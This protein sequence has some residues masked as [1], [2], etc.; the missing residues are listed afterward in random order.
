M[1][2][3]P[4]VFSLFLE[5]SSYCDIEPALYTPSLSESSLWDN[6]YRKQIIKERTSDLA[7]NTIKS[8]SLLPGRYRL[9]PVQ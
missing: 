9:C 5:A 7:M 3:M 8:K 6:N 4:H 1:P 2:V